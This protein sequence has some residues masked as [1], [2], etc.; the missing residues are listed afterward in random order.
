MGLQVDTI[1]TLISM[2]YH[3]LIFNTNF[4]SIQSKIH[5]QKK[6]RQLM[7]QNDD[8]NGN[9]ISLWIQFA[10]TAR[11]DSATKIYTG[12]CL[13][14]ATINSTSPCTGIRILVT[15]DSY[16]RGLPARKH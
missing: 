15:F 3:I 16:G 1:H 14:S 4:R 11:D 12:I 9:G 5:L 7:D 6:W 8:I 10:N 13:I 2:P